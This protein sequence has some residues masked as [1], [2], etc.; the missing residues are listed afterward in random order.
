MGGVVFPSSIACHRP[1]LLTRGGVGDGG[2]APV[3]LARLF[4]GY[5]SVSCDGGLLV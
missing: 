5:L 1:S 2:G 3:L 4:L